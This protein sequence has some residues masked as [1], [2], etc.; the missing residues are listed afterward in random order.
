M[1]EKVYFSSKIGDPYGNR[2]HD[3]TLRGW[4]LNRLTKGPCIFKQLFIYTIFLKFSQ[5]HLIH[6]CKISDNL[7]SCFDKYKYPINASKPVA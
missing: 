2:T 7:S 5:A 4:R 1:L 3:S 6:N